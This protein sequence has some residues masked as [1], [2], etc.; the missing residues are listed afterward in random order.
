MADSCKLRVAPSDADQQCLRQLF[1]VTGKR[2]RGLPGFLLRGHT[3]SC[4]QVGRSSGN[5][6]RLAGE[7]S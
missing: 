1:E 5:F 6:P 7:I 3:F 4:K 2:G